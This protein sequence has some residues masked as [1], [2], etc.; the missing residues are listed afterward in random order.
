MNTQPL[1]GYS[2]K[3]NSLFLN[4]GPE[5]NINSVTHI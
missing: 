1:I 3:F 2:F 5:C 4:D